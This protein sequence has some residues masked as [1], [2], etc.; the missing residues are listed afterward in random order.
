MNMD[1]VV[2]AS[3]F[4]VYRTLELVRCSESLFALSVEDLLIHS[5]EGQCSDDVE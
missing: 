1:L 2:R 5:S 4:L 3:F